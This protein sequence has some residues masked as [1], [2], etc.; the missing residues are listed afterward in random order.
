MAKLAKGSKALAY[1]V[2]LLTVV[3]WGETFVSSKILLSHG[4]RPADIFAFRF[5][6][7]Y[8]GMWV[9][10]NRKFLSRNWK[11]ELYMLLLGIFGG[12]LYFLTENSALEYSTAS[13]VAIILCATPLVTSIL[14]AAFYREERMRRSQFAGAFVAL[15]GLALIIFNGEVILK[16]NPLGDN[17]A[18]GAVLCWGAYS[19]LMKRVAGR[20][21]TTFVTR[22]VFGYGLLTILPYFA[23]FGWPSVLGAPA[24]GVTDG[25]GSGF[26]SGVLAD[27]VVWGN[28]LYLGIVASLAC[29]L[30]W[31]WSLKVLGTVKTTNILYLQ[32]F[33]TMVIGSLLLHERI[34]WMAI[35]GAVILIAGVYKVVK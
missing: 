27:P 22:K 2:A 34:T 30:A 9:L 33:S 23:F 6:I 26:A 18:F 19:M 20:Y 1:L 31:N 5:A 13:N 12:S 4:L 29:Y 10:S 28:L 11:D 32:P 14:M 21:D 8:A 16:L 25:L 7:A 15:V 17:L 24:S 35:L 3:V